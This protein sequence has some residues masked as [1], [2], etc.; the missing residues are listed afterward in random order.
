MK[1]G[2]PAAN[3]RILFLIALVAL[4]V[5]SRLMAL[6]HGASTARFAGATLSTLVVGV[7]LYRLCLSARRQA[8]FSATAIPALYV[9]TFGAPLYAWGTLLVLYVAHRATI[10]RLPE[11]TVHPPPGPTPLAPSGNFVATISGSS[12]IDS[13]APA[14]QAIDLDPICRPYRRFLF[15][16]RIVRAGT[17][18]VA[19]TT[20][21]AGPALLFIGIVQFREPMFAILAGIAFTAFLIA[22]G[23]LY[24]VW[25]RA[26]WRGS[27]KAG[28]IGIAF[29]VALTA[30]WT[31]RAFVE[32]DRE[33]LVTGRIWFHVAAFAVQLVLVVSMCMGSA[34]VVKRRRDVALMRL[35]RQNIG[36]GWRAAVLQLC[37]V[38]APARWS[39]KAVAHKSVVL[40]VL[41]FGIEGTAFYVY[42]KVADRMISASASLPAP[43]PGPTTPLEGHYFSF[44]TIACLVLPVTYVAT[45]AVL[46]FAERV[47]NVARRASLRPADDLL[48]DDRR[49]PVLFLRDFTDDQVALDRAALPAWARTVDPGLEQTNLEEV[50]QTCLALGPVIAIGRPEDAEPPLGAAR[51]YVRG[52]AWQD[53]VLSLMHSAGLIVVGV[54][55]SAGVTW[56]ME[57]L[58]DARLLEKSIFIIPPTRR[59]SGELA[60][61]ALAVLSPAG[62]PLRHHEPPATLESVVAARHVAGITLDDGTLRAFVTSRR[63]SQVEFD[64]AIR[65]ALS[66]RQ[67]TT[68]TL[69]VDSADTKIS[70]GRS[71]KRK[72]ASTTLAAQE[73][74]GRVS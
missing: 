19:S 33:L 2:D 56:E 52:E 23:A 11:R 13:G 12:G 39:L 64:V 32:F 62:E 17:A 37:G 53:A 30:L 54:S 31:V 34:I 25:L 27:M 51:R 22:V 6:Q 57:Q 47:R 16:Q 46:A 5:P 63:P 60:R 50:L 21:I 15:S 70:I 41:A 59:N 24:F 36:T 71:E 43:F 68:S 61:H 72:A 4:F 58:R 35:L 44:V 20:L 65:L 66:N 69:P 48:K 49:P 40:S 10:P 26:L 18:S 73:D 28:Y 74:R 7:L 38:I 1:S 45:Q 55:K 14:I 3:V 42:F 9:A 29:G 8:W 67:D